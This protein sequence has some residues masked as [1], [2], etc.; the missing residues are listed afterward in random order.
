[1]MAEVV[2]GI[3]D[4]CRQS[5]CSLLGG[6]T[7]EMPGF[8]G[9]GRYDLAGFCVAVVDEDALIDGSRV[10]PGDTI[11]AI[12]SSGVHS[13]G[14]SLVRR[15]LEANGIEASSTLPGSGEPL[16]EALLQPT[17]L[18]ASLVKTLLSAGLE[19]RS[20]AHIT[21][22]GLP[23]N[24]PRCLP[25]GTRAAVDAGSWERPLLFRWLQ[26]AG[27]VPET[28][29]WNTFNLGV[30]FCL[31][32]PETERERTLE[33]CRQMGHQ[34]WQLGVIEPRPEGSPALVGLP[35]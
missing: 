1:A 30:G 21:G 14:F 31:I 24:L 32:V 23:E 6:E 29:L 12:A 22:G 34:A 18:Y 7:A 4:G 3:A 11:V 17:R 19:L 10:T 16:I 27:Q 8:Y 26:Q 2:E 35:L 9:P 5:G 33:L 20:M 13:N 28:D 15:I 25:S